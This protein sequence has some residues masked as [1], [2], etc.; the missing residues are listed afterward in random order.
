GLPVR[1]KDISEKGISAALK[2]TYDQLNKKVKKRFL[3][4]TDMQKQ[5]LRITGTTDFSGF[6][7]VDIVVEAVFE[8]LALKQQMVADIEQHCPEHTIFAS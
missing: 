5:L 2:Y 6:H 1:I 7:D 8:D 4:K 3:R